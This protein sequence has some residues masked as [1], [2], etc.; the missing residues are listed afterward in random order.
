MI[1]R[2]ILSSLFRVACIV[3]FC[4]QLFMCLDL[5]SNQK[6]VTKT[7]KKKQ[8]DYVRPL[9]CITALEFDYD[10]FDK[11]ESTIPWKEYWRGNWST[12]KFSGKEYWDHLTP[13]FDDLISRV[14]VAN[15]S[16]VVGDE[17]KLMK[18]NVTENYVEDFNKFGIEIIRKDYYHYTKNY[19]LVLRFALLF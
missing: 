12:E 14:D 18:I 6:P 5:Y 4:Y 13:G 11:K 1:R 9:I 17:Y 19:C 3:L 10:G 8:E 15:T 16:G 7:L 2:I